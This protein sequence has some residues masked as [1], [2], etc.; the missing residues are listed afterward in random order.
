VT[1]REAAAEIPHIILEANMYLVMLGPPGAGKGTQGQRLAEHFKVPQLS[2]GEMLRAAVAAETA[3]G[4]AA[5]SV[6]DSGGLVGDDI[7][8]DCVRERLSQDDAKRGFVLDG[9]P[10][11][12]AQAQSLD[13]LLDSEKLRL[14]AVIELFVDE[15]LLIER[16][17][18][19]A[20]DAIGRGE[21]PRSDDNAETVR[22]RLE[23]Y[24]ESTAVLSN[25]YFN[26]GR[27]FSI[28]GMGEVDEVNA[29][30]LEAL[31]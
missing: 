20:Q 8:M 24:R 11:T 6:I 30:I 7:V 13:F 5:K 14:T 19:R 26:Q 28:N 3:V 22:K 4:L 16:I 31:S 29:D 23:A 18:K 2:T 9:F 25:F 21:A 15:E 17:E 10:R 1:N 12:L 27:L